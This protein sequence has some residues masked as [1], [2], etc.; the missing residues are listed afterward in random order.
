MQ[1][2]IAQVNASS[3]KCRFLFLKET[4]RSFG[5][6]ASLTQQKACEQKPAGFLFVPHIEGEH[7]RMLYDIDNYAYIVYHGLQKVL[8]TRV[9]DEVAYE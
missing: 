8:V 3:I 7:E 2:K 6:A 9:Q 5:C 4:T 1:H